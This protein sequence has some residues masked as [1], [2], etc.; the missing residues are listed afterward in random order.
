VFLKSTYLELSDTNR[1]SLVTDLTCEATELLT[2][3]HLNKVAKKRT[4]LVMLN[5]MPIAQH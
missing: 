3:V 4:T 1:N 2:V 5:G